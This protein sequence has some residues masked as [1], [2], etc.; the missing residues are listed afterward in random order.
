MIAPKLDSMNQN[1][2]LFSLPAFSSE[3]F[4]GAFPAQDIGV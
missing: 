3:T 4:P 2:N 1:P